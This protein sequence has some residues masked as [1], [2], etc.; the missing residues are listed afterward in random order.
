MK[1]KENRNLTEKR[2]LKCSQQLLELSNKNAVLKTIESKQSQ[3]KHMKVT[4]KL[5]WPTRSGVL[6]VLWEVE[7]GRM[8]RRIHWTTAALL[9][10]I[11]CLWLKS[12]WRKTLTDEQKMIVCDWIPELCASSCSSLVVDVSKFKIVFSNFYQREACLW[13]IPL[14]GYARRKANNLSLA[15]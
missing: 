8:K 12:W 5:L 13:W 9:F 6:P 4:K 15:V 14:R 10:S 2:T 3:W 7:R 11:F 1:R